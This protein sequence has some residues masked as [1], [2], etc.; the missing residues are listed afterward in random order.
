ML[1]IAE[2]NVFPFFRSQNLIEFPKKS[3]SAV[4]SALGIFCL[5]TYV[6]LRTVLVAERVVGVGTVGFLYSLSGCKL[7]GETVG[8]KYREGDL[9]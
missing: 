3:V 6:L 8:L 1:T 2:W 9:T 4:L 5:M 7:C